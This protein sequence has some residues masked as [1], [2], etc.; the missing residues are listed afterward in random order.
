MSTERPQ[1]E[2]DK[3][4]SAGYGT[5]IERLLLGS[6]SMQGML[7]LLV[8]IGLFVVAFGTLFAFAQ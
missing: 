7:R 8:Y 1:S 4:I 2:T 3:A 5:D 6:N